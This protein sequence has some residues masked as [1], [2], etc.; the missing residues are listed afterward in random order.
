VS[1]NKIT[2]FK[3]TKIIKG[4]Y[5]KKIKFFLRAQ[6]YKNNLFQLYKIIS[7]DKLYFI[8]KYLP[9]IYNKPFRAYM[10]CNIKTADK[11]KYLE[12]HYNYVLNNFK[13]EAIKNI[14]ITNNI[15][16]IEFDLEDIGKINIK[17]CYIGSLGKEGEMT[18]LLELDEKDLY[19][20][21]FSFF[22]EKNTKELII[23]GIQSRSDVDTEI[24]KQLT[25]K[26]HGV[27][28]RN[29]LF[30][31]IRQICEILSIQSIKAIRTD[32]HVANCSH[33][34]KTGKFMA[35]YDLYWE[36]ENGIKEEIFYTLSTIESRKSMEEIASKKRSMYNKR[37]NMLDE[38]KIILQSNFKK[39]LE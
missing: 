25:K 31:V 13:K 5:L 6:T 1:T 19:S 18:L 35:D 20:I 27:R 36:E 7:H 12:S 21:A 24:I 32:F 9:D 14:Y 8:N 29:Y 15:S 38:H 30:F 4:S 16:L 28:P 17:L 34:N 23:A 3:L 26:M 11:F 22:E 10:Y 2:L 37:F 39:L 33:V